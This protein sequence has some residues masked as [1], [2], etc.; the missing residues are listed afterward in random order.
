[1]AI[2]SELDTHKK[3]YGIF[4]RQKKIFGVIFQSNPHFQQI[5]CASLVV[6]FK[7]AFPFTVV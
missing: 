2:K 5:D 3:K 6:W 1:M 4:G 7:Y